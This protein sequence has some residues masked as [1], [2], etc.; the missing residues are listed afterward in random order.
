[1]KYIVLLVIIALTGIF[2]YQTYW[3]VALY[4]TE[5]AKMQRDIKEAIRISDYEEMMHRIKVLRAKT[6]GQHGSI[7]ISTSYTANYLSSSSK[8]KDKTSVKL[9]IDS[10]Q[11]V[12][13]KKLHEELATKHSASI[14]Y[15]E[16]KH[17]GKMSVSAADTKNQNDNFD[18]LEN[19][20]NMQEFGLVIQR[21]IHSGLDSFSSPDVKLFDKLFTAHL[22]SLGIHESHQL[23]YLHKGYTRDSVEF[24]DTLAIL[25][26]PINGR[27][28][29][30]NFDIDLLTHSSYHIIIKSTT[31][32]VIK[33][34]NGILATSLIMIFVICFVFWYLIHTL[35]KLKTLDEMKSDFTN[36]ITHEL[37]TPIAVAYAANDAL[38]NFNIVDDPKKMK[39]YL[40]IGQKQLQ[41][42][43]GMVEQILSMSMERRKTMTLNI[44]N[45]EL[46]GVIEPLMALQK[47]KASK[48]VWISLDIVPTKLI[49]HADR[50]HLSNIISNLIDNAI[51][52]SRDEVH[53]SIRCRNGEISVS[54]DGIGIPQDKL[55]YV[56]DKF[57]RVPN[58]NQHN[59]KGY[60]LGLY[61][62]KSIME[63]MGGSISVESRENGGTTFKLI[64]DE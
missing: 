28:E 54:D 62:A 14:H 13:K 32:S 60:G 53:V 49:I 34:M 24:T 26:K 11:E 46:Q 52:Y 3:L 45:V 47:M 51:K 56:F 38:L 29:I 8:R 57:Y 55:K 40:C 42:L 5:Q 19:T 2:A 48:P 35:M 44:E 33:Q 20:K 41:R 30:Y 64:F 6:N 16:D 23:Y 4:H 15:D 50:T 58:G 12:N 36:N 7:N 10:T 63:Q 1:M 59:V 27:T 18:M 43:N 61:Y 37:K 17:E 9:N 31:L 25:G 21:G 22:D 39:E